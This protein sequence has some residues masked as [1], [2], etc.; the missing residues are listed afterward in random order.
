MDT[1][2]TC[3]TSY[4]HFL[5]QMACWKIDPHCGCAAHMEP[6][7]VHQYQSRSHLWVGHQVWIYLGRAGSRRRVLCD[8]WMLWL[9]S[10]W[11]VNT[12]MKVNL[13]LRLRDVLSAARLSGITNCLPVMLSRNQCN[14]TSAQSNNSLFVNRGWDGWLLAP[15]SNNS[16]SSSAVGALLRLWA[17]DGKP[18]GGDPW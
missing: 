8:Q 12:Y 13:P 11:H 2:Y 14:Y 9:S 1:F 4:C 3:N 15:D 7:M 6:L 18:R 5:G 17:A 10:H 16:T